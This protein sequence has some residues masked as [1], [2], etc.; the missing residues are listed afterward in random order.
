M[1]DYPDYYYKKTPLD[2]QITEYDCGTT[3]I[4]N[5]IRFLFERKDISPIIYR[6]IMQC[7]L[8][9]TNINGE[10]GKGGTSSNAVDKLYELLNKIGPENVKM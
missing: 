1:E 10:Y 9:L 5:A 7:T 2:Y 4:L 6:E 8:D 3:T